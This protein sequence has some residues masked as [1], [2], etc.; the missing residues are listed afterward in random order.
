VIG[1][2]DMAMQ[3]SQK[4]IRRLRPSVRKSSFLFIGVIC[5][6]PLFGRL[7]RRARDQ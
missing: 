7:F 6:Y 4:S 1:T 2:A 3:K 5:G